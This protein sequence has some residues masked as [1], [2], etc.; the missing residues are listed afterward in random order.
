LRRPRVAFETLGCKLN[1]YETDAL[2]AEFVA[3]GW[4]VVETAGPAEAYVVNTCTVTDKADR[5]SRSTLKRVALGRRRPVVVVTG[6]FSESGREELEGRGDITYVVP[7][8]RKNQIPALVDSLRLGEAA[9]PAVPEADRFGFRHGGSHVHTRASLKIQ[10]G[11]DNFCSFC[12]IPSVRGRALSRP[13]GEVLAEARRLVAAGRRE[14][15]LTG[16]NLGRW[17]HGGASFADLV[18]AILDLEGDFRV[19]ITSLEPDGLGER[20]SA[21]LRHPK[22]CP[23]L[24]LCLQSASPRVL[25]SMRREYNLEQYADLVATLRAHRPDLNLTT[26]LLVGFPGEDAADFERTLNSVERFGLSFAHVFPY[27]RR[28]GTRAERMPGQV[29][30][31]EK[32]RRSRLLRSVVDNRRRNIM[33]ALLGTNRTVLVE[34]QGSARTGPELLRGLTEDY[35]PVRFNGLAAWN[36]FCPVTL[37]AVVRAGDEW[38]F[39]AS[40][41]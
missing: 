5:K 36:T 1:Q 8:A 22:L 30:E 41:A 4:R 12:I 13:A 11:C 32:L 21:L 10:D 17:S 2:A 40:P 39:E 34:T 20:F 25:L 33:T 16:V 29:S 3:L 7:N 31:A 37:T 28:Q 27:S 18:E 9:A 6:C 14:L 24:H 38:A 19:R 23:H 35:Y 26:D 15:V